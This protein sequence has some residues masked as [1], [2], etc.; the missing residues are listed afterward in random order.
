[1][2]SMAGEMGQQVKALG[3]KPQDPPGE[4]RQP[5]PTVILSPPHVTLVYKTHV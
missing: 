3:T 2:S 4:K 5:T 1:M